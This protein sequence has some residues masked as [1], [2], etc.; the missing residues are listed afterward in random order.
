MTTKELSIEQR[1]WIGDNPRL[2]I[3]RIQ[4]YFE[5]YHSRKVSRVVIGRWRVEGSK[6]RPNYADKARSGRPRVTDVA[7]RKEAKRLAK[8]G[9]TARD[10]A[11]KLHERKGVQV[12]VSTTR[13]VLLGGRKALTWACVKPQRK[14]SKI[15][16]EWRVQFCNSHL[17]AH[18]CQWIFIDA[19]YLYV[20]MYPK[21]RLRYAWKNVGDRP[22]AKLAA[23]PGAPWVFLFYGAVGHEYKS[24]LYFVAPSPPAG[25]NAKRSKD[26]FKS[27]HF[28]GM[29]DKM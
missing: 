1:K 20:Y 9:D 8:E 18:T 27:E 23:K 25:S 17:H 14:L 28:I 22:P 2:T 29:L 4:N 12:S 13:R 11:T 7:T 19:K 10:I 6:Q 16:K 24:P 3:T 26:N 5:T 15:N 21:G